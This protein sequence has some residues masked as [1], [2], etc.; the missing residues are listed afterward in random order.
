[1]NYI[2]KE[3]K[4]YLNLIYFTYRVL[5]PSSTTKLLAHSSFSNIRTIIFIAV[6]LLFLNYLY[7]STSKFN[8]NI[9]NKNNS[10]S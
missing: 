5:Q 9:T 6:I 10:F 8:F 1:M 2:Y 4:I 3:S 7:I